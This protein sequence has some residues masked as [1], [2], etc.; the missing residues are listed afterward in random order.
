MPPFTIRP[1]TGAEAE[2][3]ALLRL[4]MFED[5]NRRAPD[6]ARFIRECT[7]VFHDLLQAGNCRV[8]LAESDGAAIG[9]LTLLVYPRLPSPESGAVQE[10][11]IVNVYTARAWRRQG[12]ATELIRIAVSAARDLGFGRVRLHASSDGQPVYSA[13]G[14]QPRLDEMELS[15]LST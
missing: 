5:L 14:F 13:A 9:T 12:I 11:H 2:Q 7:T 6:R 1:A 10:G 8:W 15:L 3:L 4:Q